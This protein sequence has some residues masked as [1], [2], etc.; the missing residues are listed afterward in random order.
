MLSNTPIATDLSVFENQ[1]RGL[2]RWKL[3][4]QG[5]GALAMRKFKSHTQQKQ[6]AHKSRGRNRFYSTHLPDVLNGAQIG[7]LGR[8]DKLR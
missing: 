6:L 2:S 1:K 4:N 7:A 3:K 5:C 8:R